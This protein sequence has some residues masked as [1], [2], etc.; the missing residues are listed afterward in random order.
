M[1]KTGSVILCESR[2]K[3]ADRAQKTM[4]RRSFAYTWYKL[5]T[6]TDTTRQIK[7][8]KDELNLNS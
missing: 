2:A 5:E 4:R 1:R 8:N 6:Y 3:V 7:A